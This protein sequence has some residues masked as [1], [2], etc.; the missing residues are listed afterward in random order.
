MPHPTNGHPATK[1]ATA[2]RRSLPLLLVLLAGAALRA[3][4]LGADSLWYDETVSL[5]L[6]GKPLPDLVAH[7]A[8]DIHPP[9]YYILLHFWTRLAGRSEFA[10]AW[11]SY[12]AGLLLIPATYAL[13]RRVT[14]RPNIALVTAMLMAI[15]PYHV[16]YAQEVR[17]YTVGAL[18]A[19][20]GGRAAWQLL[21]RWRAGEPTLNT[22][23]WRVLVLTSALGLYTLYYYAFWLVTLAF[24]VLAVLLVEWL[25]GNRFAFWPALRPWAAAGSLTVLLWLPWVPV[26]YRQATDPPV[27]PWRQLTPFAD[28][29]RESAAALAFGQSVEPTDVTGWLALAVLFYLVGAFRLATHPR[30]RHRGWASAFFVSWTWGPV[31]LIELFSLTLQPLYHVRYVFTYSAPF[32][33][34][35]AAGV[36]GVLDV[37]RRLQRRMRA[38]APVYAALLVLIALFWG[39]TAVVSLQRFWFNPLYR[40]DDF[41]SAMA[42]LEAN[43]HPGD[44]LLVNAGY[45]YPAVNYYF[46]GPVAWQ[47]RLVNYQGP[48]ETVGL[49]VLQT[50]SLKGTPSLGWGRPDSDFYLTSEAETAAALQRVAARH[51]RLWVLRAYDTVTDP[52]GFIR[53]WLQ[54]NGRL[55]YDELLSGPGNFRLQGWLMPAALNGEPKVE[56]S[57]EFLDPDTQR[58]WVRLVGL[59]WLTSRL[60]GGEALYLTFYLQPTPQLNGP[61]RLSVGLFDATGRQWAVEDRPPLGPLLDLRDLS[62][63]TPVAVPVHIRVPPGT[64]P[65]T[66]EVRL[67][68]YRPDKGQSLPVAAATAVSP[69]QVRAVAV[70]VAPTP[71]THPLPPVEQTLNGVAGP[72]RLVGANLPARAFEQGEVF[73][74]ELLWQTVGSVPVDLD[75]V[76][77]ADGAVEDQDRL[78]RRLPTSRW[79][80]DALLRDIHRLMVQPDAQPGKYTLAVELRQG[81]RT[82][83][84]SGLL[85]AKE[86]VSIGSLQVEDRARIFTPP[87]V[88]HTVRALFGNDIELVGFEVDRLTLVPGESLRVRLVWR[89][90]AR[91]RERYKVFTHL[92][93]P[94]GQI[95]GQRDLEPGNGTL[96]TNGWVPGEY[97]VMEYDVPLTAAAPSGTYELRLGLYQPETGKRLPVQHPQANAQE[98]YLSLAAIEVRGKP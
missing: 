21:E 2:F 8:R 94:D 51:P 67:K 92:V 4:R 66:Y 36:L 3:Y 7:T 61:V 69:D 93:G 79:P 56:V 70:E 68:L 90:L 13:V 47:G 34:V 18:L 95:H 48:P 1:H 41:R 37:A 28:L 83:V 98:H 62:P 29:L 60:R 38:C 74:V 86:R 22:L 76:I 85:R 84:W 6:A 82:L 44:A 72:L 31:L 64:P 97:V 15:S 63:E 12:A 30:I 58:P 32:Y 91:P 10:A 73:E 54:E 55:F 26:A 17:M 23:P 52:D 77:V 49:I 50:G 53:Q 46:R 89:A 40:A 27:P 35:L 43:W 5:L 71:L 96:P 80:A 39:G 19:V 57:A 81:N 75:P 78:S 45:V 87:P 20:L 9:L 59:D 25:R 42:H 33:A 11:L 14:C 65:G 88:R 16:W 24:F